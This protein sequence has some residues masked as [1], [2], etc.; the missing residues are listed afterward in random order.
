MMEIFFHCDETDPYLESEN[1]VF[2]L[3][4]DLWMLTE[5]VSFSFSLEYAPYVEFVLFPLEVLAPLPSLV[6]YHLQ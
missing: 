6:V 5:I 2:P 4:N 1:V 3:E